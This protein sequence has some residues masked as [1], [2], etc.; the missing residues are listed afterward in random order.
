MSVLHFVLPDGIEDPTRPS[1][2]NR[3]DRRLCQELGSLG[4]SVNAHPVPGFWGRPDGSS[5]AALRGELEAMR[6]GAVVLLDGLI[7]SAAP[8]VLV[9]EAGRLRLVVLVHAP[10]GHRAPDDDT[11]QRERSTLTAAAAV[12]TTSAWARRRLIELY[13]LPAPRVHVAQPGVDP[14]DLANGTSTG[15]ALLCVA[16]VKFD[17]GH[18]LLLAALASVADLP[19]RCVC[20]GSLDREPGFVEALDLGSLNGRVSFPGARTGAELDRSYACADLLVLATRAE[21]YGLVVTEALARGLPV[22]APAVGGLPEALGEGTGGA[23]PGILVPPEDA[24]SLAAAIRQ[25]LTDA[26]LR[27]RLRRVARERRESLS[28]WSATAEAVARVV[29]EAAR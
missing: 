8:D 6:D 4:W 5:F 11:V 14:A 20:V 10:L 3:Y 17:K 12:I 16:A 7:A 13:E 28:S 18:D 19:W 2:G 23:R 21:T 24:L 9:P 26:D 25:W 22:V 1:G 15:S 27:T 29:A